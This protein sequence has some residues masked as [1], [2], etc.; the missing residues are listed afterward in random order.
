MKRIYFMLA[1]FLIITSVNA[2]VNEK[3]E[4][5]FYKQGDWELGFSS[6]IG[7]ITIQT[8]Q[9]QGWRY[10]LPFGSYEYSE[11]G[12]Y[13]NLGVS[14]GF[15]IINGLSIEPE[16]DINLC[17]EGFSVSILSNLCY[18]L[19]LPQKK[20][21]PYVKLGYGLS[22]DPKNSDDLFENI[23]F[24]TINAGAGVKLMYSSA[25]A[26]RVEINYRNLN[27]SN[28]FYPGETYSYK[29]ESTTSVVSVSIG[30]SILL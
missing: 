12:I 15:Y 7:S 26:F 3:S 30:L 16:L 28:T 20:F 17:S 13:L 11:K 9:L 8:I 5:K 14:T 19:N 18:T 1:I 10:G 22:N 23:D 24:K 25:M 2:Q 21:F 6:N 27:G 29:S 4:R